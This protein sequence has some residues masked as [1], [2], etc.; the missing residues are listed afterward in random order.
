[1]RRDGEAVIDYLRQELGVKKIGLHGE[2][3]G[4]LVA[5][6]L[7]RTKGVDFVVADRTFSSLSSVGENT[8]GPYIGTLYRMI[9]LWNDTITTD[10]LNTNC[11]KV[12]AFD[13][14]DEI[15]WMLSSLRCGVNEKIIQKKLG[16]EIEGI[17]SKKNE[18]FNIFLPHTWINYF[19]NARNMIRFEKAN[20]KWKKAREEHYELIS[21]EQTLALFHA[22]KRISDLFLILSG[23]Q[24]SNLIRTKKH[25]RAVSSD[26]A[27]G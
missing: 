26:I 11:Y 10:Y 12:C 15:V 5:T 1:M 22:F 14:K 7:A 6:H 16:H 4:G 18:N 8:F 24:Q 27:Q 2:S 25:K 21:K 20:T 3:L 19:K 17:R 9:T 13:P 23:I